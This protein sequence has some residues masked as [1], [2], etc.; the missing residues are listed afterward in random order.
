MRRR[1][2]EREGGR[3]ACKGE[4]EGDKKKERKS[5]KEHMK[6]EVGVVERKRKT[7]KTL[8]STS[9]FNYSK[10]PS[11]STAGSLRWNSGFIYI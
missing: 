7:K 4:A 3:E 1:E 11:V 6:G 9:P 5:E 2:R 10:L 8:S